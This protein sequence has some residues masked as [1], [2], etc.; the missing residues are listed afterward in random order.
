MTV[1]CEHYNVNIVNIKFLCTRYSNDFSLN[2]I[3]GY[4]L[5]IYIRKIHLQRLVVLTV[6]Q[7]IFFILQNKINLIIIFRF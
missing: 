4:R 2:E 7:N 6:H 3:I 1:I 5:I